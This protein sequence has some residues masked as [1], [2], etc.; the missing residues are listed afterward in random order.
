M[1]L[2]AECDRKGQVSRADL[3]ALGSGRAAEGESGA[4]VRPEVGGEILE[5]LADGV[6]RFDFEWRFAYLN[7]SGERVLGRPRSDLLGKVVWAEFPELEGTPFGRAYR[8]AMA[9]RVAVTVDDYYPPFDAWFEARALPSAAGL[10]LLFR[11]VTERRR[12]GAELARQ[13]GLLRTLAANADAALF[14]MNERQEC[15][16]MNGSAEAM[17]G[18]TFDEVRAAGKPLHDVIHYLH[19]DGR[20]YPMADCPIDRALPERARQKGEDVFVHKSGR[21]YPVAFTAS[22]IVENGR[23]VGTVIEVRDTTEEKRAEGARSRRL[24]YKA[25]AADVADALVRGDDVG[26]ALRGVAEALVGHLG[27]ALAR[28]WTVDGAGDE[29]ALRASA[30]PS[31]RP[32]GAHARGPVG[33]RLVGRV[34][35]ERAPFVSNDVAGELS[36][37]DGARAG[38]EG[39]VAFGGWP[40]VVGGRLAGVMAVFAREALADDAPEALASV[41]DT[42]ALGVARLDAVA[43]LREEQERYRLLRRAANDPS[44]DWDVRAGKV[45][46]GEALGPAFGY[47]PDDAGPSPSWRLER[48]HPDDRERV[49]RGLR[50]ALD[51]AGESWGDEYR[52]RRRDG[53]YAH[54]FERGHVVRDASGAAARAVGS[55]VDL[56]ERRR[57]EAALEEQG[58]LTRAVID[59]QPGLAWT[60]LPDGHVDFYNRGWYEYTG[61]TFEEMQGWGWRGVHDPAVLPLVVERWRHSLATGEPFEM[62]FPLR[63]ADGTFRWFLT[64]VRPLRDAEGRVVRWFGTNTDVDGQRRAAEE[65]ARLLASERAARQLAEAQ[66]AVLDLIVEQSGEGIIMADEGGVLRVFNPAAARQH[67]ASARDVAAADWARTYGLRRLDGSPL[68]LEEAPLYRAVCGVASRDARWLVRRPDGETRT[69]VGTA[70]PLRRPDGSPAGGVLVTRDETDR[71]RHEAERERLLRALAETNAELDQFAYVASHDLKAP[72][73]GIANLSQWIEED[74][75]DALA[76]ESREN[77]ALLRGRVHRLEALI[78]GILAYSRAGRARAEPERVAVGALLGETVGLLAP[79]PG[80]RVAIG[81]GMPTLEVERVPLQQVFLNLIGNAIKHARG[82]GAEVRVGAREEGPFWHFTVAD[83]GPGIAPEY[84]E[85]IWGIFQTLA[86]RDDV[87]GTGIGLSV[88]RKVVETRGGRAWVESDEGRGATFHVLWPAR[89]GGGPG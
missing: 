7:P 63:G 56:T 88:V 74:L 84:H 3:D 17:T 80:V 69:L 55:M 23:P 32:D 14:V 65:R 35:A 53:S 40:L 41:A 44:W 51:G 72:L 27:A 8:R 83:D 31:A 42:V 71:Q 49:E 87:E 50:A 25:L 28:V 58:R 10:V 81:E 9:E 47:G 34:A 66:K 21:F 64:R 30:G 33:A 38:G 77:M 67:G 75:G 54:V 79:P 26:G 20:P 85:R 86:A 11:D 18:F 12:A 13:T 43:M 78:D 39:L 1:T 46:W 68:P 24:R 52:F 60:A 76:G 61:A 4:A 22:P 62:E 19:P 73:R 59:N 5:E 37:D 29:L 45:T 6:I 36:A 70:T 48:V 57:L 89:P 2:G 82:G 15:T 16:F